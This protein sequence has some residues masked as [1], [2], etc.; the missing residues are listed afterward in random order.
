MPKLSVVAERIMMKICYGWK[1]PA[2]LHRRVKQ[3]TM[4]HGKLTTPSVG[5]QVV[6]SRCKSPYYTMH[7]AIITK[8][9]MPLKL[10][11]TRQYCWVTMSII[12]RRFTILPVKYPTSHVNAVCQYKTHTS[13]QTGKKQRWSQQNC[14]EKQHLMI[15]SVMEKVIKHGHCMDKCRFLDL[16]YPVMVVHYLTVEHL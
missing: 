15:V 2:P 12:L 10:L 1:P 16:T 13:K 8:K 7:T 5:L 14:R 11:I 9:N 3:Y 4:L 6:H